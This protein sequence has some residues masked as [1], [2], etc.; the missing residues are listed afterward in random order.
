MPGRK[1]R[2]PAASRILDRYERHVLDAARASALAQEL[3]H[4]V[5]PSPQDAVDAVVCRP[6]QL[7]MGSVLDGLSSSISPPAGLAGVREVGKRVQLEC[8][9]K[10]TEK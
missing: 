5:A 6:Q 8:S 4:L 10:R 7:Q 3:A 2:L 9:A 1:D